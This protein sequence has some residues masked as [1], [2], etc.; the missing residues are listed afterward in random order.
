M[1]WR[2]KH[3]TSKHICPTAVVSLFRDAFRLR[4]R[5][6]AHGEK[7]YFRPTSSS[8]WSMPGQGAGERLRMRYRR[9]AGGKRM[10][11]MIRAARAFVACALLTVVATSALADAGV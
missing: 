10:G 8:V 9:K 7:T 3:C 1:R 11:K 2:E 6:R 4:R 5:S